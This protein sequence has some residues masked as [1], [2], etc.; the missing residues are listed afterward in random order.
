MGGIGDMGVRTG[1]RRNRSGGNGANILLRLASMLALALPLSSGQAFAQ[2]STDRKM[3]AAVAEISAMES[4]DSIEYA[5]PNQSVWTTRRDERGEP[6]NPLLRLAAVLF[7][8]AGMAWHG[9]GYPAARLF[10]R[11]RNGSAQF[12]MLVNAPALKECC[13]VSQKPVASTEL[14]IYRSAE[15]APVRSREDLVGQSVITLLGYSYGGLLAFV[16][17]KKNG[18]VNNVAE[19]HESAFAMLERGRADYLIDYSG[20]A[21]EVLAGRP[22]RNLKFD[23]LDRLEVY[24]VLSKK[25]A[26]AQKL[27]TRLESIA[28]SLNK[29]E[30]LWTPTK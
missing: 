14:N 24:L 15:K 11:L 4:I 18:I 1:L 19:T 27:M 6:D 17:D 23:V 8:K 5:Y 21:S 30:I 7:S 10:E 16:D 25:R 20:P 22:A 2:N 29:P 26:D 12:S 9:K 13:L 3:P 28:E